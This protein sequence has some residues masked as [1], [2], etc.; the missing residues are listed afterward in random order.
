E[1]RSQ[2]REAMESG[3]NLCLL[4]LDIDHF[5]VFNDNY[6]HQTGDQV[7]KLLATTMTKAVKGNDIPARYGGEEFAVILPRTDLGEA[8]K[9]AENIRQRVS[10][11]TL[12]N[13][14]TKEDLGR[15]TVSIGVGQFNFG[16]S[17]SDLISRADQA[18]YKAKSSGRD[19][20]M[21]QKELNDQALNFE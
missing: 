16:E 14:T 12:V 21:S 1:L 4:M 17:L 18:L 3:E 10:S 13:R 15:L 20:V 9:V 6:G 7:L 5:K 8:I 2:A 11:K 19:R